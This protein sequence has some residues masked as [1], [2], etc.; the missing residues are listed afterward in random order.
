MAKKK[1]NNPYSNIS[2]EYYQKHSVAMANFKTGAQQKSEWDAAHPSI[3]YSNLPSRRDQAPHLKNVSDDYYNRNRDA[4]LN[5]RTGAEQQAEWNKQIEEQRKKREERQKQENKWASDRF[6]TLDKLAREMAGIGDTSNPSG[7][8]EVGNLKLDGPVSNKEYNDQF[9]KAAIEANGGSVKVA[10]VEREKYGLM[11]ENPDFEEYSKYVPGEGRNTSTTMQMADVIMN[12]KTANKDMDYDLLYDALNG[13]EDARKLWGSAI[14]KEGYENAAY[15]YD[16]ERD[17]FNYLYKK[18]GPEAVDRYMGYLT[19]QLNERA[20]Q[21]NETDIKEFASGHP[22]AGSALSVI[23]SPFKIASTIGQGVDY[24]LNGEVDQNANYNMWAYMPNAIRNQVSEDIAGAVDDGSGSRMNQ[25]AQNAA[26]FGYQTTLSMLDNLLNMSIGNAVAAGGSADAVQKAAGAASQI[27]MSSGAAADTMIEARDKGRSSDEAL[28]LATV[29]GLAEWV[30]EKWSVEALFD[31]DLLRDN[32]WKY[33][34]KNVISEGTEEVASDFINTLADVVVLKD[35]SEWAE[36]I[37]EIRAEHPEWD[38]VR[39]VGKALGE[40]AIEMGVSFLGGA[41]SGGVLSGANALRSIY[42]QTRL[43]QSVNNSA[44]SRDILYQAAEEASDNASFMQDLATSDKEKAFANTESKRA[45]DFLQK[46]VE[47]DDNGQK[48]SNR[49]IGRQMQINEDNLS[50]TIAP[51]VYETNDLLN[52]VVQEAAENDGNAFE[53]TVLKVLD[54]DNAVK[55]LSRMTG[56]DF[57]KLDLR[58]A[59]DAV[60]EFASDATREYRNAST[61]AKFSEGMGDN[62][63]RIINDS[64]AD[65]GIKTAAEY[66]SAV[67]SYYSYGANLETDKNIDISSVIEAV[68]KDINPEVAM[69]AVFAG[70]NDRTEGQIT[71]GGVYEKTSE[72]NGG[73]GQG[74]KYSLVKTESD[75]GVRRERAKTGAGTAAGR[76]REQNAKAVINAQIRDLGTRKVSGEDLGEYGL[77]FGTDKANNYVFDKAYYND[78]MRL[79]E[80]R[81]K[82]LGYKTVF[83][84]GSVETFAHDNEGNRI[85]DKNGNYVT[86]LSRG[87]FLPSK[88]TII[89]Q[90]DNKNLSLDKISRHEYFHMLFGDENNSERKAAVADAVAY[91]RSQGYDIDDMA[92]AYIKR[93]GWK[94]MGMSMDDVLEEVLADAYAG[95]DIWDYVSSMS[96]ATKYTDAVRTYAEQL[97]AKVSNHEAIDIAD[98]QRFSRELDDELY[99]KAVDEND[100]THNVSKSVMKQAG[101]DRAEIK[102]ILDKVPAHLL[103][104]EK[105]NLSGVDRDEYGNKKFTVYGNSSYSKSVENTSVC[106][107]SLAMERLFDQATKKMGHSITTEEAITLSQMSW[108]L[109]DEPTCQYCYVFADRVAERNARNEYI[110]QRD[111]A[112]EKL[113]KATIDHVPTEDELNYSVKGKSGKFDLKAAIKAHP[114]LEEVYRV[115][116]DFGAGRKNTENMQRRFARFVDSVKNGT[117]LVK[118]SDVTTDDAMRAAEKKGG[119]MADE[120]ADIRRYASN[121]SHA[122]AKVA[123]TAYNNDILEFSADLVNDLN[124]EY[125][126]RFYSYSDYHP[127]FLLENMQMYTDAAVKGLK[128]LAYTKDIDYARIFEPTGANINISTKAMDRAVRWD[129]LTESQKAEYSFMTPVDGMVYM[130]DAMQGANWAEAIALRQ[131]SIENGTGISVIMVCTS[132]KQVEWAMKQEWCDV[133]IP[134]HVVFSQAIKDTFLWKNY[135]A[136]QEDKKVKNK[137]TGKWEGEHK[138]ITPIMHGNDLNTYLK[139]LEDNNLSPRFEQ[140]LKKDPENYMKLVNE[141]RRSYRDTQALQPIFNMDEARKVG[142]KLENGKGYDWFGHYL[143]ENEDV[144]EEFVDRYNA[145]ERYNASVGGFTD[146]ATADLDHDYAVAIDTL[147]SDTATK[148]AKKK[149]QKYLDN[150]QAQYGFN[151][152]VEYD[153]NGNPVALSKRIQAGGQRMSTEDAAGN[154]LSDSQ[155]EYFKDSKIRRYDNGKLIPV[156]H[157]SDTEFNSFDPLK[158]GSGAGSLFGK[159]FY[160]ANDKD[161]ADGYGNVTREFYLNITNPF[162]Y[163]DATREELVS[164]LE[165]SGYEYDKEFVENFDY[166]SLYMMDTIDDYFDEALTNE[167]AYS[168][169]DEMLKKSGYDGISTG[170]E[171]VAFYPEQIKRTDNLHPTNSNDIRFSTEDSDGN[172]LT[173]EQQRFFKDSKARD[174]NGNLLVLWHGTTE[175]GFTVFN[176]NEYG[177]Y[178]STSK[179]VAKAYSNDDSRSLYKMYA[180][181]KNPL[182]LDGKKIETKKYDKV[183]VDFDGRTEKVTFTMTDSDGK[184][185]R[186]T[187]YVG[188]DSYQDK[189]TQLFGEKTGNTLANQFEVKEYGL[190]MKRPSYTMKNKSYVDAKNSVFSDIEYNGMHGTDEIAKWA[191]QNGYDGVIVNN[192]VD[193]LSFSEN[194]IAATDVI[195]FKPEQYKLTSNQAPTSDPDIRYSSEDTAEYEGRQIW[196]GSANAIDGVIEETHT[197]EEAEFAD[198]H[199]SLYFSDEQIE[200]INDGDSVFFFISN[201]EVET[202]WRDEEAPAWLVSKIRGQLKFNDIRYSTESDDGFYSLLEQEIERYKG[203]KIGASSVVSYL[204]GKGVKDEEIKWT[205]IVPFLEGKKSVTKDELLDYV[206]ANQLHI[207]EVGLES[208]SDSI[209]DDDTGEYVSYDDFLENAKQYAEYNGYTYEV[210]KHG[211]RVVAVFKEENGYIADYREYDLKS[212][213][214]WSEYKTKGG[215]NY[216]EVLFKMPGSTYSNQ[217]MHVHWDQKGVLAHARIQDFETPSGKMLFVE[218]IQSDWHNA[219]QKIGYDSVN[220]KALQDELSALEKEKEEWHGPTY[221]EREAALKEY[222]DFENGEFAEFSRMLVD[223]Y[224]SKNNYTFPADVLSRSKELGTRFN[225][226]KEKFESVDKAFKEAESKQ[227]EIAGKIRDI[228]RQ[229]SNDAVPDAPFKNG[230]YVEYVMKRLLRVAAEGGYDSIGWTTGEMQ[231]NRWSDEYAEGYRIEY[232]QDIPKFMNKYGKQWGTRV[233]DYNLFAV[234]YTTYY[235]ARAR[236][237]DMVDVVSRGTMVEYSAVDEYLIGHRESILTIEERKKVDDFIGRHDLYSDIWTYWNMRGKIN[238]LVHA[239]K[240]TDSMKESVLTKGQARFSTEDAGYHAGDL[241]KAES[242][243]QQGYYRGTGHFG[244]GTYFVGDESQIENYNTRNGVKAPH[245]KVD[246]SKYNLYRP[247]ERLGLKLHEAL[248]VLDGGIDSKY[249]DAAIRGEFQYREPAYKAYYERLDKYRAEGLEW[250]DAKIA[251]Y[252]DELNGIDP[253]EIEYE[254]KTYDEFFKNYSKGWEDIDED[255]YEFYKG[256]YVDYLK[257]ISEEYNEED[258][259]MYDRLRDAVFN[260]QMMFGFN[261]ETEKALRDTLAYQEEMQNAS[262]EKQKVSDSLATVF[263]KSLGY[264]GIDVRGTNLDNV[265]YG[266][267]IYDLKGKDLERKKAIG[268][269]RYSTESMSDAEQSIRDENDYL[270]GAYAS[271]LTE[272]RTD[273]RSASRMR[274]NANKTADRIREEYE[275]RINKAD[276]R[277]RMNHL[278]QDYIIGGEQNE[279]LAYQ[280]AKNEAVD[281]AR[282]IVNNAGRMTNADEYDRYLDL[283][284][285]VKNNDGIYLDPSLRGD[286]E[287]YQE[288]RKRLFGKVNLKNSGTPLDSFYQGLV[289]DFGELFD[290]DVAPGIDQLQTIE[291]VLNTLAPIYENPYNGRIAEAIELCANDILMSLTDGTIVP[292][293][294]SQNARQQARVEKARQNGI[295]YARKAIAAERVYEKKRIDNALSYYRNRDKNRLESAERERLRKIAN[296]LNNRKLPKATRDLL[297]QYIGELDLISVKLTNK[298]LDNLKDLR[299]WYEDQQ[300]NNPDFVKDPEIEKLLQ[301]L[302]TRQISELDIEEVR[303]LTTCL[304]NIENELA[305]AKKTIDT[306]DQRDIHI[307]AEESMADI[308]HSKGNGN[309]AFTQ[310]VDSFFVNGTLSPVRAMKRIVG[311]RTDS[312]IYQRT[313]ELE[314]GQIKSFDWQRK[315]E[316]NFLRWTNDNRFME[317]IVGKKAKMIDI[318][319]GIQITPAMRMSLYLHSKNE[320][321]MRHII[322]GGITVPNM[323]AYKSGN[324]SKAYGKGSQTVKL[325]AKQVRDIIAGMT[326]QE[327][328]FADAAAKYFN[329]MSQES[330]NEVS[331]KLKGYSLALVQNYF[332]INTNSNFT[333]ADYETVKMDGTIEG[334][335]F[336]KE[337]QNAS[338]PIYLRDITDVLNKSISSTAKYVGLAIPVRNFNKLYNV[339][340]SEF[341]DE[342]KAALEEMKNAKNL[343]DRYAAREKMRNARNL[344]TGSMRESVMQNWDVEGI[345]YIEKMMGDIQNPKGSRSAWAK[346]FQNVRGNYAGSTLGLS[347]SVAMKQAASYPTAAAVLGWKPLNQAFLDVTKIGRKFDMDLV[348][349]YTPLLWHRA[350]NFNV[351]YLGNVGTSVN[352]NRLQKLLSSK[353]LNWITD[354]DIATTRLLWFA[355]E[356]YVQNENKALVKGGDAYYKA[357]A[358]V[359]NRVITETQP[360]YTTMERPE[361]LRTDDTL[362]AS[363][364]MFKTQ[365]FQNFNVL[366]DA[367]GNY[368][369]KKD[370]VKLMNSDENKAALTSAK[371]DLSRAVSSQVVQTFVFAAMTAV[372]AALLGRKDKYKDDD[373]EVTME[374][375]G[376]QVGKDMISSAMSMVPFGGEIYNV[377]ARV[378]LGEKYYGFDNITASS[379]DDLFNAFIKAADSVKSGVDAIANGGELDWNEQRINLDSVM[380]A[381][382]RTFGIPYDN[383][384][385]IFEAVVQHVAKGRMG[386]YEG[387]YTYLRL[388]KK[389]SDT[390]AYYDNLFKAYE[391]DKKSYESLKK[392]MIAD[393]FDEEKMRNAINSRLKDKAGVNSVSDLDHKLVDSKYQNEYDAAINLL[394][395]SPEYKKL[396]DDEQGKRRS[397]VES[398]LKDPEKMQKLDDAGLDVG[399]YA[400]YLTA[401]KLADIQGDNNGSYNKDEKAAAVK[402][403]LNSNEISS[404]EASALKKYDK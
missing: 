188:K 24:A 86:E 119:A 49:E 277:D 338:N 76:L 359:Y 285:R 154:K 56:K 339:S 319:N 198:F 245:E 388:T 34:A 83:V 153:S 344:F 131:K 73:S 87:V 254:F 397:A 261:K 66:T 391:N 199:H 227:R 7:Y 149:A 148:A 373:G 196:S 180:D 297:E 293:G 248:K 110:K 128:G 72:Q 200:K 81:N 375:L 179:W 317:S 266:S 84:T 353:A 350:S 46:V 377:L 231:E 244:T 347:A 278:V 298:R 378:F 37:R 36:S 308:D 40:K 126:L 247:G 41:I 19:K 6:G 123:Y 393:G 9:M 324:M 162:E 226:L 57:D 67:N 357:V 403:L 218:E 163:Y 20:R 314:Q 374:S 190:T 77:A 264:E 209:Y 206:R 240:L 320:Q 165:N 310:G 92:D 382:T 257:A 155:V 157:A 331:E 138:H 358:D 64:F 140:W 217:A 274:T 250:E 268:T 292:D 213:T 306:E 141:T 236:V 381:V 61:I 192:V 17:I 187:V 208:A 204:K 8:N 99:Q 142:E 133:I 43:G 104:E 14:K 241:G 31:A 185:D 325:N 258:S 70:Y 12:G 98:Q 124:K 193:D 303:W 2:D 289:S 352:Q 237:A 89:L 15:L 222:Q 371:K 395:K 164:I 296:R 159:G 4:M 211:N 115:Y 109:T 118:S 341:G 132:D 301:R 139:A 362:L 221:K 345:Q 265:A 52:K 361:L 288:I 243:A 336:L 259:A 311:Y 95:I 343:K 355:S 365:S 178:S 322:Y 379:L 189:F 156:Y 117:E 158:I 299:L 176:D 383:A 85:Q 323:K 182:V 276:L 69:A 136:W 300:T 160:F 103:P 385:K 3:D 233:E 270:K 184:T 304:R 75:S 337:R 33:I 372:C 271:L 21:Q 390:G 202:L 102:K 242:Y 105:G 168:V 203:N 283:K 282:D 249:L 384:S 100:E 207:E 360:N 93:Y 143:A 239:M 181:I 167:S 90:A 28:T 224:L 195:V 94:N 348:N 394:L 18:E 150:I 363:M 194:G 30:T 68:G 392:K 275:S 220:V 26:T 112:I 316:A 11:R 47:A 219:G 349:R 327:K 134:Y 96:G 13:D 272:V 246:F 183:R 51:K 291:E 147:N 398:T 58:Q 63:A 60:N 262:Y 252:Q 55:E 113:K 228:K 201:G 351:Q 35:R 122:K 367:I 335:G 44:D 205:G 127:A 216:R 120:I 326:D 290:P 386:E 59:V 284:K 161:L 253:E 166:D 39:V 229:L 5:L 82:T 328:T 313:L 23:A 340:S 62:G 186:R 170:D 234:D 212:P 78:E 173:A 1:S 269:A 334:M 152:A 400:L 366:Y 329:G 370:A 114:E 356:H 174:E 48:L 280:N 27:I 22:V 330:I 281:I 146:K 101:K 318:G 80:A 106:I 171:F 380:N 111:A 369:A 91:I 32:A 302:S 387:T 172:A 332:P 315:A 74:W 256:E 267:V 255:D 376:K 251:A 401:R 144:A 50:N 45:D 354:M 404:S 307:Q 235:K 108:A 333:L 10:D 121:A 364:M 16:E 214:R 294:S 389:M 225:E 305:I 215:T 342:A 169:L 42:Y 71:A 402:M 399:T 295:D 396:S 191:K 238:Q 287:K 53:D 309:N 210:N 279:G 197:F 177:L 54:D 135:K 286:P 260:L 65:S 223:E 38:D 25:F 137:K 107:R 312:P 88:K 116:S 273:K 125:G 175:P 29:A 130:P 263:M 368:S 97:M 129:S 145:G 151:E 230:K 79:V 321:N 346:M 232:D